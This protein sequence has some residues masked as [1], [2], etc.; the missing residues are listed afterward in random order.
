[1]PFHSMLVPFLLFLPF[2]SLRMFQYYL[3]HPIFTSDFD[4]KNN[5]CFILSWKMFFCSEVLLWTHSRVQ[6][7]APSGAKARRRS[8]PGRFFTGQDVEVILAIFASRPLVD[9]QFLWFEI[10]VLQWLLVYREDMS[11]KT[12]V[13]LFRFVSLTCYEL[14]GQF[15]DPQSNIIGKNVSQGI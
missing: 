7:E 10:C 8:C 11:G 15:F 9:P 3:F 6:L 13:M 14:L 1:M 4:Q 5:C 2:F 12:C